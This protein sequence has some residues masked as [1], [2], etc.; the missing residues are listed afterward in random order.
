MYK[1]VYQ[2]S[3]EFGATMREVAVKITRKSDLEHFVGQL[4]DLKVRIAI[5]DH[6]NVV[7][8]IGACTKNIRDRKIFISSVTVNGILN[9]L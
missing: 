9:L 5:G 3:S 6:E 8:F 2:S 1:A 7:K 4:K